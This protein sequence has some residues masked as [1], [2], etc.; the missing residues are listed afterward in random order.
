MVAFCGSDYNDAQKCIMKSLERKAINL[1]FDWQVLKNNGTLFSNGNKGKPFKKSLWNRVQWKKWVGI[2]LNPIRQATWEK[3]QNLFLTWTSGILCVAPDNPGDEPRNCR[4]SPDVTHG[5]CSKESSDC[6]G[7]GM[8]VIMKFIGL[9]R[10]NQWV[11]ILQKA[12]MLLNS[13]LSFL[14]Y[15][16]IYKPMR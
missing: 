16:L 7:G 11:L 8:R 12:C 3:M 6:S 14:G 4:E 10:D 13:K 5:S 2:R 9:N 1:D 15:S